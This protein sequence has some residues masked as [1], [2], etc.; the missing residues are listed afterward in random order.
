MSV[1]PPLRNIDAVPVEQDGEAMFCLRDPEGY[2]GEQIALS[3]AAFFVAAHLDGLSGAPA[4]QER[5][6]RHFDGVLI[7]SDQIEKIVDFLDAQGFLLSER[8]FSLRDGVD[9]AF[10]RADTRPASLAGDGYPEAPDALRGFVE[11]FY[12]GEGGPGAWKAPDGEAKDMPLRGLIVPHIDFARGGHCY[13]H[14]YGR[15][16]EHG[17]P[18]TVLVFGVAHCGAPAPFILTRKHFETPWGN[19]ETDGAA[20]DRLAGACEWDPFAYEPIHR[21]E[22]S[23]EFQ[24]VMLAHCYGTDVRM[25]PVLCGQFSDSPGADSP[26]DL[27]RLQG[28]LDECH[29][30]AR[31]PENRVTVI[32]AADLAHVGRRFGDDFDIDERVVEAVAR[33][34]EEDLAHAIACDADAFYASVMRDGNE[35][36]VCG[37]GSIYAMLKSIEG[38]GKAGEVLCYDY[39][40]DPAG[41][42]VSF[43]GVALS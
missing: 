21:V 42:I 34:D 41:G 15:L 38:T 33:R 35:R 8:F 27:L 18:A 17:K 5:F 16:C 36:K 30:L 39:G 9:E 4:I 43:A 25:V 31:D 14:G 26:A 13:A 7:T 28:F 19:I 20:V 37:L 12:S 22:H 40:H 32:A 10:R 29:G 23:V 3:P 24:A 1:F 6:A 11:A 2:A